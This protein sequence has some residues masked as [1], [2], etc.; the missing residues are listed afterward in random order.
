[1][2]KK[3]SARSLTV[4]CLILMVMLTSV[5]LAAADLTRIDFVMQQGDYER[6]TNGIAA[7]KID[8]ETAISL[9]Q[10]AIYTGSLLTW[11][12]SI[13]GNIFENHSGTSMIYTNLAAVYKLAATMAPA[14]APAPEAEAP[15]PAVSTLKPAEPS[16]EAEAETD[17]D[18]A[19]EAEAAEEA[20]VVELPATTYPL[21]EAIS[22]AA[23]AADYSRV[24]WKYEKLKQ[25]KKSVMID[26]HR[27]VPVSYLTAL[28]YEYSLKNN[29]LTIRVPVDAIRLAATE[30]QPAA[31]ATA[32][33]AMK[34]EVDKYKA[35]TPKKLASYTTYY[36]E[37]LYN[38]S[39]NLK[40]ATKAINGKIVQPG[41]T[42]SFN[43][44]V[45][46]RTSA[47]GYK[48]AI[49]FVGGRQVYGLGGGICQ[50]SSTLYNV[51]LN[52]KMKV[53]ERRPHGLPV[54]YVPK[55]KDA[56]VSWGSIDFKF[57]NNRSY[58][59]KIAAS[60]SKGTLTI[61]FYSVIQ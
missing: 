9:Y 2:R 56:T 20:P 60:A 14:P 12:K 17:T 38:R 19:T 27:Y 37:G 58:P 32:K 24:T 29:V 25:A 15:A 40:L 41:Q 7:T 55:G 35:Q 53:V 22:E 16:A 11:D 30:A 3:F 44:T 8:G 34:K 36:N 45:G 59:I 23:T 5:P 50:V 57:K 46:P 48:S 6:T 26:G 52:S 28:G 47:R 18:T 42:F 31:F 1:M 21:T 54:T 49:V 51:V 39:T 4:L 33:A 43:S 10:L 61:S 13:D